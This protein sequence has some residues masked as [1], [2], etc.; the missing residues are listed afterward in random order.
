MQFGNGD[1]MIIDVLV[2]FFLNT[3]SLLGH[4]AFN[5]FFGIN[6]AQGKEKA[7]YRT[8][9]TEMANI[10]IRTKGAHATYFEATK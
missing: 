4:I 2:I 1:L 3:T 10:I 8:R 7:K 5:R 6:G 9:Q